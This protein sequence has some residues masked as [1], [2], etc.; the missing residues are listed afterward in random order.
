MKEVGITTSLFFLD[1]TSYLSVSV[2]LRKATAYLLLMKN[3]VAAA[4]ALLGI[5]VLASAW[6]F[7][8]NLQ[9][10]VRWTCDIIH[11]AYYKKSPELDQWRKSCQEIAQDVS[12]GA[13][14]A[15]A[16][17]LLN[18]ELNQ[19][20]ISHLS[21]YSPEKSE[22]M[23]DNKAVDNGLRIRNVDGAYL[24]YA[25]VPESA[26]SEFEIKIGD[27]VT[28]I[29]EEPIR[30]AY[31]ARFRSGKFDIRRLKEGVAGRN[32]AAGPAESKT[33]AASLTASGTVNEGSNS[34]YE[35]LEVVLLARELVEDL[36]PTYVELSPTVGLLKIQSFLPQYFEKYSWMKRV[37]LF[38]S[39]PNLIIDLRENAG[40]NF[41]A[42]L[43]ALSPFM[44]KATS[45]GII[46]AKIEA[47]KNASEVKSS[48]PDD[49]ESR[50]QIDEIESESSLSLKTFD[51]YGC[52]NA[53][54]TVLVDV[55]TASTGEIFAYAMSGRP[56]SRVWGVPTAG[57]VV[58]ARWF[59]LSQL[60]FGGYSLS[61][62]IAGFTTT[63]GLE[64]EA[65]GITPAR[66]LF[67]DLSQSRRGED[68]WISASM[69]QH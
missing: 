56:G 59:D 45:V 20:G 44:C 48:L 7:Q 25:I 67:Y 58:V 55:D 66:L 47:G 41:V 64:L 57:E 12:L 31:E 52:T 38:S 14:K 39:I 10:S 8:A 34:N 32:E 61:V 33:S 53:H 37:V 46:S 2:A 15:D 60:G 51:G 63:D 18:S 62:P 5:V 3:I 26:A 16:I 19:V 22:E 36:S 30:S 43:R 9:N 54:V 49:L 42:M 21:I 24:I 13:S 27:E 50:I 29:N 35:E 40:G 4:L 1:G 11:E 23:W 28:K 65:E 68:S 6:A 69:S 17:K